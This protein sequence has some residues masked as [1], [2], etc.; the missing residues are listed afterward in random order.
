MWE[1]LSIEWKKLKNYRTFWILLCLYIVSVIGANY[2]AYRIQQAIYEAKQTKGMASMV[3][4]TPPYSFPDVWQTTAN[5][6]SYLLFIPGLL[7]IISI[8]NE[9]SFKTHRQNVI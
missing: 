2:I 1:L 9:F 5:V 6:S 8:S 3:L 7:L 4:G